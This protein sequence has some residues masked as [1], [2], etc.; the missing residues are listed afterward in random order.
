MIRRLVRFV[1]LIALLSPSV[2]AYAAH[3]YSQFGE[4]KY[5]AGFSHFEWV[6]PAAPKGG[7][8]DLVPPLRI[9]N[10]DKYNP[11]TLKG[12][13][14]PSLS[15]LVFES[16]LTGTMDEP[17]TAYGL[18]AEDVEVAADRRSVTFRLHPGA[19]FHNGKPVMAEDVKHT[20]DTLMSKQAAPQY[21]VI[22][23]DVSR[24][25]VT[26]P[27]TVRFDFRIASAELPLL[28]GSLPVF[29]RDW[30][31]GKPF[32]EVVM[33]MPIATGPYRI[34]RVNFGRDITY[35]RDPK[36]WARDLNVRRGMFN[37]DRITYRIYKDTTAQTEGFKAGEFD[38]IQ[39]FSAREWARQY[40]GEKFT[41]GELIKAELPTKNAGDFQGYLINIRRDKFKDPRVREALG[42]AFDFEWMNRQ[43]MFNA[44][45]RVRGFFNASDFEAE[46]LPGPDELAVLEPL[47]NKLPA[48]IFTEPVPVPPSTAPPGSLRKNLLK[49]RDL[50]TQAGWTYRDG[51]LRNAKGEP[52]V[53]E[54]LDNSRGD[55]IATPYFQALAKLGIEGRYRRAD[56]ALIRKR[57]DVFDFDLFVVRIPGR[58]APGSELL[59]RFG[60]KS[61]K[62]E[63]SSNL[64]G[65]SDPAIDRLLELTVSADTRP[66][67]VARLRAL[68]RVLRHGHYVIPQW[69]A[70]TFRIAY[71]SGKFGIPDVAPLYYQPE[72]WVISTWWRKK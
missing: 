29:S 13:A 10:F 60:S 22:F 11:Y 17:T 41:S 46:G 2:A 28:V 70:S 56:F 42:L 59:D 43:I 55:I 14:P 20:F 35:Q 26:G 12:T 66:E 71:R 72:D 53:V 4:I 47:R 54:Y 52:F 19:R 68:D 36:Y 62:T 27:R 51:A 38:Y 34:G 49:A 45:K 31:K 3:A 39:V 9:T 8:I 64:I 69:Y 44:Y 33:D 65:I 50:L 30:G 67:L 24:A 40:V 58:E 15:G 18:L 1:F 32:D 21:R 25:V 5:P 61:A 37:F 48:K 7:D 6:N 16:L 23:G 63:G 57:L